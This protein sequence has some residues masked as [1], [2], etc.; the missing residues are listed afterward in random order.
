MGRSVLVGPRDLLVGL[1]FLLCL[2]AIVFAFEV[3]AQTTQST[4]AG[5][6][7]AS[8]LGCFECH[9][10]NG[11]A[12]DTKTPHMAGQD[13]SYLMRQLQSFADPEF[14]ERRDAVESARYHFGMEATTRRLNY[15]QRNLLATY[16]SSL[17]C[18]PAKTPD[19]AN[20][21]DV[22][23]SCTRCHGLSGVNIEPGVPDLSGQKV[24]YLKQ[25]LR[26]FRAS[27][28]GA[29]PASEEEERYHDVMEE[30]AVSLSDED[31]DTI[32]TY[33]STFTCS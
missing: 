10:E 2:T 33:F 12:V 20:L 24:A 32:A 30:H 9:G 6:E 22:V 28:Y 8:Q 11:I 18:I 5:K 31:I 27:R 19:T 29:D 26:A 25:Q 14:E 3:R 17:K 1:V 21:P 7:F 4:E 23:K 16:F 13:K 15:D